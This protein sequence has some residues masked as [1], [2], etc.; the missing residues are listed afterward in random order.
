ME[1]PRVVEPEEWEVAP[2]ELSRSVLPV[3]LSRSVVAEELAAPV[4]PAELSTPVVLE[5]LAQ[6]A[7]PPTF[8]VEEPPNDRS[9]PASGSHKAR[10]SAW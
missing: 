2:A 10:R 7:Q 3:E 6:P 5:G 8:E 1:P 9:S 4:E